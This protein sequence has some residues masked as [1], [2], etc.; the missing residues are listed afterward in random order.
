[1]LRPGRFNP[2]ERDPFPILC[3]ARWVP[4]TVWRGKPTPE[5]DPHTVHTVA[6]RY[7]GC[8]ILANHHHFHSNQNT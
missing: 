7:I 6:G 1:M 4:G 2:V 8:A 3:E 5:I